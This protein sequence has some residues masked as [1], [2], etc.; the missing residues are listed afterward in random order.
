MN[1]PKRGRPP[2]LDDV[3]RGNIYGVLSIGGSM[4]MAA[5]AVGCCVRTIYNTMD[6]DPEFKQ[7]VQEARAGHEIKMLKCIDD[8]ATEPRYW[9]AAAWKLERT[10]PERYAVK[11]SP[12]TVH[13]ASMQKL[14]EAVLEALA[15]E[16]FEKLPDAEAIFD[17]VVDRARFALQR[18]SIEADGTLERV[19]DYADL[20]AKDYP[21]AD[22]A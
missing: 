5:A 12:G 14:V 11:R 3:K 2:V 21:P 18:V 20:D 4:A 13:L 17:R 7:R 15:D 8:A 6:R 22:A 1:Q 10:N 9:R 16:L 19:L